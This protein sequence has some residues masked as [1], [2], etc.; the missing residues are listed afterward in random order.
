M[1]LIPALDLIG[2]GVV[3]LRQGDYS[4]VTTYGDPVELANELI[5]AGAPRLHLVDL[6]AAKSGLPTNH[7]VIASIAGSAAVPVQCG[8]GVR[9][10]ADIERLVGVGID[11]VIVGTVA[12]EDPQLAH[13]MA[14]TFP[15]TVLLGLD[16]RIV[17][18]QL[19][20]AGRG[21][22]TQASESVEALLNQ[23]GDSPFAGVL[24]TAIARDGTLEGPDLSSMQRLLDCSPMPVVASGGVGTLDDLRQLAVLAQRS[25]LLSGVV[26]GKAILEGRFSVGEGVAACAHLA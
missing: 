16:Y 10:L 6:D 3:R 22:L 15:H 19:L 24:A 21:W 1:E 17:D 9:T 14:T 8:G 5:E 4:Q 26:V 25:D 2:G 7:D 11:R 12:L 23:F 20:P 18:D 13:A